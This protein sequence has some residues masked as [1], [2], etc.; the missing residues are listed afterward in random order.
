VASGNGAPIWAWS[1]CSASRS[2]VAAEVNKS[3]VSL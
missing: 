1:A 3:F 2:R